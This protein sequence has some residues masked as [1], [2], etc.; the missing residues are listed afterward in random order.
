MRG[1]LTDESLRNPSCDAWLQQLA[2]AM[3]TNS[4]LKNEEIVGDEATVHILVVQRS[5]AGLETRT[6]VGVK[7]V[8]VPGRG[9]LISLEPTMSGVTPQFWESLPVPGR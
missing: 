6:D 5:G 4:M 8:R 7:A 1:Y 2:P 9:W 3:G